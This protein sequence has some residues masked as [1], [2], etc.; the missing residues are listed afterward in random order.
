M[1]VERGNSSGE[2]RGNH[3]LFVSIIPEPRSERESFPRREEIKEARE[4]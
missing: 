3:K 4:L 1:C 2:A